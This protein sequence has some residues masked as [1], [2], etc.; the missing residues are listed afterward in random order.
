VGVV[1]PAGATVAEPDVVGAPGAVEEPGVGE[2][3]VDRPAGPDAS[4]GG[5]SALGTA[6]ELAATAP[7]VDPFPPIVVEH[8]TRPVTVR[9]PETRSAIAEHFI[10]GCNPSVS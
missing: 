4:V 1:L 3:A 9:H 7:W 6:P 5:M 8:P 2:L 10:T